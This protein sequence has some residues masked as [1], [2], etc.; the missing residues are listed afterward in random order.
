MAGRP[1]L[2]PDRHR[3]PPVI[4]RPEPRWRC[5]GSWRTARTGPCTTP[6][7]R[8]CNAGCFVVAAGRRAGR[9]GGPRRAGRPADPGIEDSLEQ[10]VLAQARGYYV[11][12]ARRY[13]R[14][15]RWLRIAESVLGA[16]AAV[17]AV[18]VGVGGIQAA[19][20][21]VA[22]VST[23]AASLAAH[24]GAARYDQRIIGFTH[25]ATRLEHLAAAWQLKG[26]SP[27]NWSRG[28]R[29]NRRSCVWS[30]ARR[31]GGPA[32]HPRGP[33]AIPGSSASG[34]GQDHRR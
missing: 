16:T 28:T 33:R 4:R 27:P 24:A 26:W 8:N 15:L 14:R 7:H 22:V 10:R 12:R 19:G 1:R 2:L 25:T 3:P 21:W 18:L 32:R 13:A 31:G 29:R 11:P 30:G 34:P 6:R 20:A 9:R 17:R 23:V 5:A